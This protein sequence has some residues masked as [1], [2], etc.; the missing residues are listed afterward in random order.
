MF[1]ND[2]SSGARILY[3]SIRVSELCPLLD[4]ELVEDEANFGAALAAGEEASDNREAGVALWCF[5]VDSAGTWAEAAVECRRVTVRARS[6]R[7]L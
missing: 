6:I 7:L 4:V 2:S 5:V 1:R 3:G